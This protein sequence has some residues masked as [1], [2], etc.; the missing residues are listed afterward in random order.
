MESILNQKNLR[1]PFEIICTDDASGD[2]TYEVLCALREKHPEIRLFQHA[3]NRGG[4]AARNTCVSHAQGDLIFCLDA[5]NVLVPNSVQILIDTLDQTGHDAVAFGMVQYFV[6]KQTWTDLIPYEFLGETYDLRE[7]V[8]NPIT[9]PWSGN[10]LYTKE[11]FVRV[12]GYPKLPIDTYAF[13]FLQVQ[14]GFKM[15]HV[16]NTFYLNRHGTISYYIR[17]SASQRLPKSFFSF[18]LERKHLFTPKTVQMLEKHKQFFAKKEPCT[19][20][21]GLMSEKCIEV[22]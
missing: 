11:S 5:D 15:S 9:P 3:K 2:Q 22:R 1:C 6:G 20:H 16:P 4:G 19:D 12:G 17:E 14:N 18:L 21:I 7:I 13:G 8:Q 10:Y